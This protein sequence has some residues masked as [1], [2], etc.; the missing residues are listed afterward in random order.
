[1]V[2]VTTPYNAV[3]HFR[4][5]HLLEAFIAKIPRSQLLAFA[6]A[7]ESIRKRYFPGFRF[8]NSVPSCQ[9]I[10]VAYKKEIIDRNNGDLASSLCAHWIRQRPEIASTALTSLGIQCADP[11][12][13][14]S[15]L[16]DVHAKLDPQTNEDGL[17]ALVRVLAVQFS[18][19]EVHIFVSIISHGANLQTIRGL[20]EQELLNLTNDPHVRKERIQRDLEATK[21]KVTDLERFTSELEGQRQGEVTTARAALDAVLQQDD[22]LAT[23]LAQDETLIKEL[24]PQLEEI[25]AKLLHHQHVRDATTNQ[26]QRLSKTIRQQREE[27]SKIQESFEKRA[28]EA[29]QNLDQQSNRVAELIA[30]LQQVEHRILAAKREEI[31]AIPVSAGSQPPPSAETHLPGTTAQP[32]PSVP[33]PHTL[34]LDILGNNAICYQGLQRTF[35]NSVVTFL[36]DRIFN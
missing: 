16:K 36:R 33:E 15:W 32:S 12:D 35:R 9:Q 11:A 4:D 7:K 25:K 24:T 17:R 5:D 20:V 30:E 13:A 10:L 1:M 22:E 21:M 34:S 18:S 23:R 27:L 29:K 3:Y 6:H 31:E 2:D 14:Y 8:S 26:K 19:E 28:G